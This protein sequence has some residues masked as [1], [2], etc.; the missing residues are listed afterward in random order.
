MGLFQRANA[1]LLYRAGQRA[2]LASGG[3]LSRQAQTLTGV[4]G[5]LQGLDRIFLRGLV[6][7]GFHG[8]LPEENSL[9]QKFVVDATLF[10]SLRQAGKSDRLEDTVNYAEVYRQIKHIM[11]GPHNSLLERVAQR[12][13]DA[14][15][16]SHPAVEGVSVR[17][18]KPHVAVSG[19]VDSLGVE[20]TRLRGQ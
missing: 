16:D 7:H 18:R 6:F 19:V 12:L 3:L 1:E 9:G 2:L 14:V 10:C 13:T 5:R 8:A 11:E 17:I 20:I 4:D 15:M